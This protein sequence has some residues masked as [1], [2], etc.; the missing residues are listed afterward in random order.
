MCQPEVLDIPQ[1]SEHS[2]LGGSVAIV[3]DILFA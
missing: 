1:T 2:G 3:R